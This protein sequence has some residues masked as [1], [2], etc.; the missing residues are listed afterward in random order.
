[1]THREKVIREILSTEVTYT[2]S[3]TSLL[4]FFRSP[5]LQ[6]NI[7]TKEQDQIIFL[8][9]EAILNLHK[10]LLE[11]LRAELKKAEETNSMETICI[12]KILLDIVPW[13][14][15][16]STYINGVQE[17]SDLIAHLNKNDDNFRYALIGLCADSFSGL[18][19]KFI[20]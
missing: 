4:D 3:L 12:G 16:Y 15:L 6:G 20:T 8:N 2:D 13:L 19:G 10:P 18:L 17:G 7:I 14:R 9:T 11:N 1:M 5:M